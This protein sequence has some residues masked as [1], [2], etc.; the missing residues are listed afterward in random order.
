MAPRNI[1]D[2]N[3]N[4]RYYNFQA[5]ANISGNVQNIKFFGKF[6]TLLVDI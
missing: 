5:F 2:S 6:S 1:G 4:Y 3:A